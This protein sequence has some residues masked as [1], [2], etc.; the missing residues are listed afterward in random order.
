M[1]LLDFYQ[2]KGR[3]V[4]SVALEQSVT[5]GRSRESDVTLADRSVSRLHATF[6]VDSVE[7]R[8]RVVVRDEGSTNG[9]LVN[10]RTIRKEAAPVEPGDRI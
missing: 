3:K 7:G 6:I 5:V 8:P 2:Q 4:R 10:A 1:Y 9:I